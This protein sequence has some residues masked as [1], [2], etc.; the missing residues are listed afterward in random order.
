MYVIIFLHHDFVCN[1]YE[2]F[3][4][5]FVLKR[6][7]SKVI[8]C[9]YR[10]PRG[11]IV[12]NAR[13]NPSYSNTKQKQPSFIA[14]ECNRINSLLLSPSVSYLQRLHLIVVLFQQSRF[15]WQLVVCVNIAFAFIRRSLP[16]SIGGSVQFILLSF[17]LLDAEI[18]YL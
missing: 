7:R 18:K 10:R 6:E 2:C 15:M 4:Q 12:G 14:D 16:K 3:A 13:N 17:Q 5:V 8:S 11:W 9:Q 1:V